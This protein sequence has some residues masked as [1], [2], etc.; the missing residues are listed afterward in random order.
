MK[1]LQGF[2]GVELA[3]ALAVLAV[4]AIAGAGSY[5]A[6]HDR[7]TA[8]DH[9]TTTPPVATTTDDSS[10]TTGGDT[11]TSGSLVV[12]AA[13]SDTTIHLHVGDTFVLKLGSDKNWSNVAVDN[14]HVIGTVET[15]AAIPGAQGMFVAKSAGTASLTVVGTA[16]CNPGEMCPQFALLYKVTFIVD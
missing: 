13:D 6:Y 8:A 9:A 15:F 2:I 10:A 3:I 11:T 12:T 14:P 1:S 7:M 4:L 5:V 16:I